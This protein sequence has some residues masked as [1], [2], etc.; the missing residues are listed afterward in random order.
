MS[1]LKLSDMLDRLRDP[2]HR[3]PVESAAGNMTARFIAT[4][5]YA[6][7]MLPTRTLHCS[8]LEK[9]QDRPCPFRPVQC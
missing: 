7:R 3:V 8:R 6:T 2:L 4:M 5:M 9:T 1:R